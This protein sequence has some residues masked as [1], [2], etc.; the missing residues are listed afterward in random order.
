MKKITK[1]LDSFLELDL[2]LVFIGLLV[3]SGTIYISKALLSWIEYYFFEIKYYDEFLLATFFLFSIFVYY[4]ITDLKKEFKVGYLIGIVLLV[5]S[6]I[7][8][9]LFLTKP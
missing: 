5:L 9:I 6:L 2:R 4:N 1:F 3:S 7:L 8:R